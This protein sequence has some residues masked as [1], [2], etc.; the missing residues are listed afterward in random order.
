MNTDKRK[1]V[2]VVVSAKGLETERA[3][4]CALVAYERS[5]LSNDS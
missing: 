3:V 5:G 4:Q 2:L 1:T